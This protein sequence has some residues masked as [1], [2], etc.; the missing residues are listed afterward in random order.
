MKYRD[1]GILF[2][3]PGDRDQ[4]ALGHPQTGASGGLQEEGA[5]VLYYKAYMGICRV[6][7]LRVEGQGASGSKLIMGI[8]CLLHGHLWRISPARLAVA[9]ASPYSSSLIQLGA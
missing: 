6:L 1:T 2:G 5:R 4:N 8:P 7:T 3:V 9:L